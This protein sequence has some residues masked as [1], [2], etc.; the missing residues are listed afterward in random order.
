MYCKQCGDEVASQKLPLCSGCGRRL[1]TEQQSYRGLLFHDLRRT[2]A[3]HQLR[4]GVCEAEIKKIGGWK[5]TA[6]FH[7]Y[8]IID[9]RMMTDAIRRL[10][11]Y[12]EEQKAIRAGNEDSSSIV[13]P[14][15]AK[16]ARQRKSSKAANY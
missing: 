2:A 5:I 9:R 10:E 7:R 12:R 16:N 11:R 13:D 3:R 14:S 4:A 15:K 1:T 6:M 8:A